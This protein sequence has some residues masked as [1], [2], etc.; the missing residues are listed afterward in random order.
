MV[1]KAFKLRIYPNQ[2]QQDYLARAFGHTR[3]VWN[4]MLMMLL[5]RVRTYQNNGI[6]TTLH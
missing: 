6:S 2:Q 1:L 3:W 4:Q 5:A